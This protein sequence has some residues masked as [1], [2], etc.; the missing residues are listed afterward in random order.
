MDGF[1]LA[2]H[3]IG[4][5]ANTE[6]LDAIDELAADL[7]GDRR[8]RIEHAQVVDPGDIARFASWA[9]SRRCSR[10]IRPATG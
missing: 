2:I 3:A 6:A 4:D 8:W 7:P 10:S 9:S 1:Q 5:R